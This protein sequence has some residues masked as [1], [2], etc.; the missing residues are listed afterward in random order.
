MP[1]PTVSLV[2]SSIR[3]KL[4]V[5]R[6]REYHE[7]TDPVLDLFRRKEYVAVIDATAGKDEIQQAIRDKLGLPPYKPEN[8]GNP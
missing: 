3:M 6:L 8:A 1:A 5:V 4:P 2:D 7:K